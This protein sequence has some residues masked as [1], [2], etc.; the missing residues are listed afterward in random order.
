MQVRRSRYTIGVILQRRQ[1]IEKVL[2]VAADLLDRVKYRSAAVTIDRD[3]TRAALVEAGAAPLLK[4]DHNGRGP[5][6]DWQAT[7]Q[8]RVHPAAAQRQPVREKDL[9]VDQPPLNPGGS[10]DRDAALPS[11]AL[12]G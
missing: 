8:D 2:A 4:L 6:R 5:A 7:G 9:D 1:E 3:K 12:T 10:Q 11:A